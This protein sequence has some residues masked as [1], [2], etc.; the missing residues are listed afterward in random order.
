MSAVVIV[1]RIAPLL[2]LAGFMLRAGTGGRGP[3]ARARGSR[4][5]LVANLTA[6]AV[7]AV[8]LWVSSSDLTASHALLVAASGSLLALAGVAILVRSRAEL[9]PAW[10]LSPEAD[11]GTG[12]VTTGPYRLVRHPIYL[13]LAL[14]SL[15]EALAF[16]S[17]PAVMIVVIGIVPTF[18]W[19][20]RTEEKLLSR[21]FGDRY[22]AYQ[23]QTSMIIPCFF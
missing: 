18:M 15:G 14:L 6:F 13:G 4:A 19:R 10:S 5:P 20:A 7:W 3:K 11:H 22:A 21:T 12:L 9:G 23:H 1:I 17:W 8:S 16:A 2:A